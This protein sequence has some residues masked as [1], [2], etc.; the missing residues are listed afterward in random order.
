MNTLYPQTSRPWE[1]QLAASAPTA[2]SSVWVLTVT[3]ETES[4]DDRRSVTA[5]ARY[6]EWVS[7]RPGVLGVSWSRTA[8]DVVVEVEGGQ[9]A[10][11]RTCLDQ[12][13]R[14][15]PVG[16]F[17]TSDPTEWDWSQGSA[18]RL[19]RAAL[20]DRHQCWGRAE[21]LCGHQGNR[22]ATDTILERGFLLATGARR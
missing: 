8:V 19:A 22:W 13:A 1:S 4:G 21:C 16:W 17:A 6:A 5:C 3:P 12:A 14:L 7:R 15:G 2:A 10:A 20:G 11:E 18:E 9:G